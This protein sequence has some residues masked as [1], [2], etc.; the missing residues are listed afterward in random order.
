MG[1]SE[2]HLDLVRLILQHVEERFREH[3]G[4]AVY[5]DL[6]TSSRQTHS[7]PIA[8]YIPDVF[9]TNVPATW[10]LI[11]EAKTG[12]DLFTPHT[13]RQIRGFL[14]HLQFHRGIFILSVP[15]SCKVMAEQVVQGIV[16]NDKIMNVETVV[17]AGAPKWR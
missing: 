6:P 15:W 2:A 10:N 4:I 1:E 8:G 17:L 7:P 9:V 12:G 14:D 3:R 5:S 13:T 16:T 11:G